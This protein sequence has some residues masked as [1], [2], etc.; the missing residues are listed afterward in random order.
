MAN[1]PRSRRALLRAAALG[2]LG[3]S[4]AA[5][6]QEP[7]REYWVDLTEPLPANAKDEAQRARVAA[8]QA[9]VAE[10]MRAM[11]IELTGRVQHA[12]NALAARMT[13]EQAEAVRRLPGV[14][15]VRDARTLH[16]PKAM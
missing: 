12:R 5:G 1:D 3:A 7:T 10:R 15:R 14:R 11:G 16:P 8:Q 6:A 2:V 9:Q 4:F 13:R